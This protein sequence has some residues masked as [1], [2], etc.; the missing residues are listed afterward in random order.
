M[1]LVSGSV[2][3]MFTDGLLEARTEGG[4]LGRDRL[5]ELLD[6]MGDDATAR[7]LVDA[8]NKVSRVMS[9]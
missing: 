7:G 4:L 8:V 5:A 1:P 9:D 3:A 6:E 2:A